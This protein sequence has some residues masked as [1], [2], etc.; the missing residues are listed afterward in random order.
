MRNNLELLADLG[1]VIDACRRALDNVC[2]AAAG[3]DTASD[4]IAEQC[5]HM[6]RSVFAAL[7]NLG[8]RVAIING[9]GAAHPMADELVLSR[10][11]KK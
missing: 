8:F 3:D 11:K 7:D 2:A 9:D 1:N 6:L 10:P 4:Y 5:R